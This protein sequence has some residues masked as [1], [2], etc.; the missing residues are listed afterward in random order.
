MTKLKYLLIAILLFLFTA[1]CS[2]DAEN[3]KKEAKNDDKVEETSTKEG[4]NEAIEVNK[5][6]F[7]VEITIPATVLEGQDL[8]EVISSAKASGISE[9]TKNED[10]SITYKMT[11]SKHKELMDE[12][13]TGIV[14]YI[15]S[16]EDSEDFPSIKQ[17]SYNKS[18]SEFTLVTNRADFENSLDEFAVFGIAFQAMYYQIFDGVEAEKYEVNIT[19]KDETGAVFNTIVYPDVLEE[20]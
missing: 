18:L 16:V 10:G 20:E 14:E 2:A 6:L 1:G 15:K 3:K 12:L 8:E 13:N 9:V 5:G 11:K 17:I 4:E 7:N 19:L